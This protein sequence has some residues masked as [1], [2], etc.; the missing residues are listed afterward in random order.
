MTTI[1]QI[2]KYE[3]E[4]KQNIEKFQEKWDSFIV[5]CRLMGFNIG[6]KRESYGI[7]VD[8]KQ[9]YPNQNILVVSFNFFNFTAN[10]ILNYVNLDIPLDR[11]RGQFT[12]PYGLCEKIDCISKHMQ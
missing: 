2:G 5:L 9:K 7:T 3:I 4:T 8:I 10:N 11:Y 12:T 1:L 6:I